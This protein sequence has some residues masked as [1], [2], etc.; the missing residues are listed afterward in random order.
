MKRAAAYARYSTDK[1]Y[2][3]SI[4]KQLEDIK[5]Y[6]ERKGYT[7]VKVYVDKAESAAKEDRPAFRQ[8]L[9]DAKK[10]LFDVVVV[11]K[12]NRLARDRYLSVITA[13]EL[14]KHNVSVESV[15]EPINDSPV[16]QLLWGILDAVNEFERLNTIQEVKMKMRPLAMKGY[17]MGGRIPYGFKGVRVKDESGK[18]HT[19]L[20]VNE[21]EAAVVRR[22]FEMF[23]QGF[24]FKKIAK[25]LNEEGFTNRGKEWTF[26]AVSEIIKNP[27]YAGMHFWG[28]GTKR[29]HRI[30]RE[31][32]IFVEGPAIIDR[33]TWEKA[34][35]RL[36][37]YVKGRER[38]YNYILTGIAFCECGAP[39]HGSRQKIPVYMCRH[40]KADSQKHVQI[41]A[42]R[43]EGY[44]KGYLKK[45][46]NPDNI[47]FEKLAASL[48]EYFKADVLSSDEVENLLKERQ[49]C[50]EAISNLTSALAKTP[51]VA[52]QKILEEIEK[53]SARI[54]EIDEMLREASRGSREITA[55]ELREI[56]SKF[57]NMLDENLEEV[58]KR[59]IKRIVVYK[60]GFID[61]QPNFQTMI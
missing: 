58:V 18:L 48:N 2:D 15:L 44:V 56:Y 29:N 39:L 47:D 61:I 45:I 36:K 41:S 38:K 13:H 55:E 23:I 28:K 22:M 19:K 14:K 59:M 33:E 6:C 20:E 27:R 35:E 31:D 40:Y 32:A 54:N 25:I 11:H 8:M 43:L 10:H 12:L 1:Q 34:Q 51:P 50:E 30:T 53:Y 26:S 21:A 60:S 16:G 3:T 46:L 7:I 17:W 52:Q 49:E 4:E 37:K 24:T 5:A 9:Q 57:F 42:A